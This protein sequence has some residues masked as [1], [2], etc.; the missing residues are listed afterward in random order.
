MEVTAGDGFDD[1]VGGGVHRQSS[2]GFLFGSNPATPREPTVHEV[3][4]GGAV[5]VLAEAPAA[6]QREGSGL[7]F[8]HHG[9][10]ETSESTWGRL[11]TSFTSRSSSGEGR[12]GSAGLASRAPSEARSR[13]TSSNSIGG[14]YFGM[15][16]H[17]CARCSLSLAPSLPFCVC[18]RLSAPPTPPTLALA[19]ALAVAL[20]VSIASLFVASS[21][22]FPH[23]LISFS[24]FFPSSLF[25]GGPSGGLGSPQPITSPSYGGLGL[26]RSDSSDATIPQTS[27]SAGL[28]FFRQF[29]SSFSRGDLSQAASAAAA[30][31]D[32]AV[33]GTLSELVTQNLRKCTSHLQ[34]HLP[35]AH[36]D[37]APSFVAA[38][39]HV[40]DVPLM[41][42]L[43]RHSV[44]Y[45]CMNEPCHICM[46]HV[47]Y[48]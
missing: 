30:T 3:C 28:G 27:P 6:L 17:M 41:S 1:L 43:A 20:V 8:R 25:L 37:K 26:F 16:L 46:S 4:G 24:R 22:P 33:E 7:S 47:T 9:G 48:Y 39:Q 36:A 45:V 34:I 14:G 2:W 15:W 5:S 12:V 29:S 31:T 10:L 44:I 32:A 13:P 21:P 19:L 11:W 35:G 42:P 38:M 23:S 18:V 40:T